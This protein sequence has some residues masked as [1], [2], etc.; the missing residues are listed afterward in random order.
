ME[1]KNQ[2]N[3]KWKDLPKGGVKFQIT[4]GF[5]LFGF[6]LIWV[7]IMSFLR[8][9]EIKLGWIPWILIF[10]SV[11]GLYELVIIKRKKKLKEKIDDK[12]IN[13]PKN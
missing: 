3:K 9:T 1:S 11:L 6:L 12:L 4:N 2:H 13:N 8:A 5:I 7:V 10:A